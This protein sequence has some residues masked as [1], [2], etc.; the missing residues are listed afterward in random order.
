MQ[1]AAWV[2]V[3]PSVGR[4]TSDV[5][6]LQH[7][8]LPQLEPG[9]VQVRTLYL[10][11]D[12]SN[13]MWLK[14]LPGWMEEVR[15]GDIMKGPSIAVVE[16]SADPAL[17]PGDIVTG[18]LDWRLRSVVPAASLIHISTADDVPL[19][20]HLSIFSHVGKAALIGMTVVGRVRPG[21]VVLVSGAAG[22]TGS[23]ACEIAM[24]AGARVIGI[25]GGAEK[26]RFLEQ[27]LGLEAAIDYRREDLG[28]RLLSICPQG[29]DMFFDNVGGP[30]LDAAL[31]HLNV[32]ARVVI[33]GA[34]SLYSDARPE[35]AY[36]HANL[37]QLLMK[38]ARIEGFVVPDFSDRYD[39]LDATLMKLFRQGAITSR[40]H[41]LEG[42]EQAARGLELLLTGGNRGKL[43]VRV[44]DLA[45]NH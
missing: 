6:S 43:L 38:R 27:E 14:L 26:C 22:A 20:A 41:V 23:L 9:A 15:I 13:L 30:T 40:T 21:D 39:E 25:A 3:K 18:A 7:R 16:R 19:E 4:Y 28:A 11:L 2:I 1:D 34:I 32:N 24:A 33:C 12:P 45:A 10:S 29:V 31:V 35:D 42:L 17:S 5:L 36:R 37:F 8:P 44:S